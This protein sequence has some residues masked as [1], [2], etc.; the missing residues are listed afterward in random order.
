MSTWQIFSDSDNDFRWEISD[1]QSL[2]KPVEEASGAPIQPYDSTSR[3]PSMVDLLLQGCSKILEN[4]GPCVESP[5]MF[6]TGLGKS[7]AVKQSSIAK[8]LSV[9]GDDDFGAGGQD[10]DTDNGCGV[11]NSLFQTASGKMVNISS[12]GLVRA[13]TLLGLEENSNHHSCQ[14]QITKQSVMDGLDGGQNASRLEMQEDL[15]SIKSED[16]KPVPRPFS[17]STSWRTESINEA[18]PNLKQ[19]EIYNPAP[20]PPPIKFHTAG[21]RSISVSSDALQ[22]ARSLL[23]DPELGTSLNEGDEDDMISSFLKGS[24]RDASS[25]KENDSDTSLSHHE[26]EKSK[27]ASKSFIS[28]IRLFPNRVQSSVMP[29]NTYSGSNLIK[30][31]ADDSKITCP[32]EP[33]SNRHCAPHTIIDNSV[34]NGNC[35][36]NKPLGRSSG[37]PLVD[38]SNRI[39]TVLTNKKQTITE[40]R[41]LGRR[42]SISP[43]KRPR[44]SKFC[45]PL[46]S[47]VSFVPNGLST[48]ASEDT[49]CRKR[50]STRYPFH[51][52]RMYI[53]E[54][55]GVLPF[56]KNALE[57]LSDEVRWM[58]PDNAEKYMFPDEYGL[59]FIGVDD[60]CQRLAQSGASMQ[61]A[62]K[63]WIANHYKWII[64]KLACYERC[65]PAKHMGRFFT[66]SNV[67]EELKYRY[68]RE[69]NHGHR[70]AIKR[71]LEGDASP[72]TMVVL[73]I[74]AI[75]STCDMKIGTHSVSLNG[76]ENSDAAKVELTDGWYSIDACLDALLSKQL[77]AGKLFIGQKLR[78]WGAGLCGWVG[79]IS[80]LE[81]SKTAGLLVHI[82][83]T[84]RAHWADRL[85]FCKGVGPPL[86]FRCIKSHG[87]PVPQTLVRVTRIYPILYKERLSN[88][89][90][91]IR[92]GRMENKMMQ[93]YN[94]RCS[95]VVEGI[96][97]EF[98]RGTRDS[99]INNDNDSEEGAKIFEIL[100]TAAEPEV[101]MAEMTSEQLASFT[102]YQAKL[103]A[104]R[105]SD[106]QKSIEM[107]LEGAGLSTREVTPFMRVRVVGLT[108]KSYEGKIRHKEGLITIW[109]PTEKQQFELVEG[110]AYAVAGLMPLNSDS[111]TLYLQARGSTTK[112]NPLSPLA[113]EHFEPFLN[114]RKSV[115]L[116][117]LGEIPL[118]R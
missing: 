65:Y 22:R 70:S 23:G 13:K 38:V 32:Q 95:T 33:L 115:L 118:S 75:H 24:F 11:S 44:S 67:L 46:N 111:E 28:P 17:T 61:Y 96:I 62:S 100:E 16:A 57:H 29:E 31:Y 71:I 30:K 89:G 27:H 8:A 110:Q 52:P 69:V 113:I 109:N 3:L 58:N 114:P 80:P 59:G 54:C 45:P 9:L 66:M 106:L 56:K 1:G 35:S 37:G 47:N 77:F 36:I 116:S 53:K 51:V 50:V 41:R 85:G 99:C 87:G 21:G 108:C 82:N 19:S 68:E 26:K 42:S 81:T 86:A 72:S 25:N 2:T 15:N 10:H 84:Y 7:V 48:L 76:S 34:A 83:G 117:N 73:C 55:F 90:S 102:S 5:P 20:N 91:I 107:A 97:S 88:G 92:S 79:P 43:F 49:C 74:S 63:E 94:Q 104:I 101:L 64:W 103:E 14:E 98:Q 6:R 105:Q 40:K 60:L 93:L 78:I 18:V 112:W 12:A 39:G 4:C